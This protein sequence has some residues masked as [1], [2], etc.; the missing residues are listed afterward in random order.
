MTRARAFLLVTAVLFVAWLAWLGYAV[1]IAR[2]SPDPPV[3]VSRA[4]LTAATH[5]VV[6][7][8]AIDSQGYP[9]PGPRVVEV[10]KGDGPAVG[11]AIT[12]HRLGSAKPPGPGPFPGPGQYLLPLVGDGSTFSIAGLPRSP[13]YEP[14]SVER[15][16]VYRWTE[17]TRAQLRGLGLVR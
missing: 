6:A 14:G 11:S 9:A 15:P 1:Y 5:L 12:V 16:A 4:Q 3:V 7:D 8:V 13:G 17:D 2:F 10:L